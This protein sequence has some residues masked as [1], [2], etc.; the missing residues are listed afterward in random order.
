MVV[1]KMTQYITSLIMDSIRLT[2][3][4]D[5]PTW[6]TNKYGGIYKVILSQKVSSVNHGEVVEN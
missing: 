2:E 6:A 5:S 3:K 1:N 4:R